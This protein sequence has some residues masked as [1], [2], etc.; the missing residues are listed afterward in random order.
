MSWGAFVVLGLGATAFA[1]LL[2]GMGLFYRD[3]ISHEDPVWE[4]DHPVFRAFDRDDEEE[5]R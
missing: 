2:I 1:V 5:V 3:D 4:E